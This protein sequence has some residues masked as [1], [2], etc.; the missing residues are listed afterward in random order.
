VRVVMMVV[1]MMVMRC[2]EYRRGKHHQEQGGKDNLFHAPNVA[3][4]PFSAK[5][6]QCS[7]SRE[8]RGCGSKFQP[9][10]TRNHQ[11]FILRSSQA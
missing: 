10:K 5:W 9:G 2:G 3:W 8:A 11:V 4:T 6:I 1:A 7:A